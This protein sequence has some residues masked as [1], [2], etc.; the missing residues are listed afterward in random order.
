MGSAWLDA[1]FALRACVAYSLR[2][3]G[4]RMVWRS[5]HFQRFAFMLAFVQ[6]TFTYGCASTPRCAGADWHRSPAT[7]A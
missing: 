5:I 1:F 6:P 7:A 3:F 4:M 2:A